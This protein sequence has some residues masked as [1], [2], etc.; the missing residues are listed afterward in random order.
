MSK[1]APAR[2]SKGTELPLMDL[3]GKPYL[4]V[5]HRLVWL[6]DDHVRFNIETTFPKIDDDQTI[7][8][9]RV[10][11]CS[12]IGEV[13]RQ[14]T[15]TKRE[16]KKDFSDHT[17]KAETGAIGRALAMLGFGTQFTTQDLDEGDRLADAPI[18]PAKRI[19]LAKKPAK[20]VSGQDE[21]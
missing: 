5:A 2:T 7:C 17:E 6:N 12:E 8:Q 14:A 16:T 3:R 21:F 19:T 10:M 18:E 15:A 1:H 4:Q 9:A 13:L 11:I 20:T